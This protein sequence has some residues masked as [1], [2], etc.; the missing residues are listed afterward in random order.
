M[1]PEDALTASFRTRSIESVADLVR[2][3]AGWILV[4]GDGKSRAG[5]IETGRRFQRMA[6]RA[7]ECGVGVHPMTQVLEEEPWRNE[8]AGELGLAEPPQFILRVG[9]VDRYPAPVSLRRPV[10]AFVERG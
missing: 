10:S 9:L 6:L 8:I 7:R 4:C 1:K 2:Q 5:L 3:G